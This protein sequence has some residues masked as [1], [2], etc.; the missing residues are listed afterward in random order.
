MILK[1][2]D[3]V[4]QL[5]VKEIQT[6]KDEIRE[7]AFHLA[8]YA[9]KSLQSRDNITVMVVLFRKSSPYILSSRRDSE[10]TK[11]ITSES[12][13]SEE[14]KEVSL[15]LQEIEAQEFSDHAEINDQ[16]VMSSLTTIDESS[17]LHVEGE[18]TSAID[19]DQVFQRFL[20]FKVIAVAYGCSARSGRCQRGGR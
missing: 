9:T 19:P 6:I 3:E 2:I 17:G 13:H 16:A 5:S 20:I 11:V 1:K 18:E 8:R 12:L 14:L 10:E 7:F 4:R 15:K